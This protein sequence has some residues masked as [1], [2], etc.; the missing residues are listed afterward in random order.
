MLSYLE[1]TSSDTMNTYAMA[2]YIRECSH[3]S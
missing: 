1:D 3:N 2:P